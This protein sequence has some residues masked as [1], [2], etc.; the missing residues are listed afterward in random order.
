MTD[1]P[2]DRFVAVLASYLLARGWFRGRC[3]PCGRTYFSK[4]A[5]TCGSPWCPGSGAAATARRSPARPQHRSVAAQ[6]RRLRGTFERRGLTPFALSDLDRTA[7]DTDLVVSALQYLDPVVHAAAP[8][9]RGIRVLAQP[10]VRWQY[11]PEAGRQQ[12]V[13]TSFVNLSS[14]EVGGPRLVEEVATHL[15][16]WL[17]GLSAM[18]I[19]AREVVVALTDEE[20]AYGPYRGCRADLNCAG[21]EIGEINWYHHVENAADPAMSVIDFGFSFERIAWVAARPDDYHALLSPIFVPPGTEGAVLNDRIRTLALLSLFGLTPG[22]RGA[23]RRLRNVAD[24]LAVPFLRGVNLHGCLEHAG[25]FWRQFVP[26]DALHPDGL[27]AAGEAV[28]R[29]AIAR[30]ATALELPAP[31]GNLAFAEAADFLSARSGAPGAVPR[32]VAALATAA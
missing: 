28:E 16:H 5:R 12:G 14:L 21:V 11:Q 22:S 23:R 10:C 9:P 8:A 30:L 13:S 3:A 2:G 19:H 29:Q 6:W 31:P 24:E 17:E 20:C 4:E 26:A 15:D 7:V 18:G 32:A 27:R 1:A 25:R